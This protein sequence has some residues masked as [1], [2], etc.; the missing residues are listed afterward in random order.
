MTSEE[1]LA[2]LATKALP[3]PAEEIFDLTAALKG[4]NGNLDF[5]REIATSLDEDVPRL[6]AD[7]HAAVERQDAA[8]LE[9]AAHRLKGS[10]VPFVAPSAIKAAQILETM[11]HAQELSNASNTFHLLDTEIQRLL[12]ALKDLSSN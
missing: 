3:A 8:K 7:I 1:L 10:L 11:G 5:L 9:R 12:A 4:V 6:V 2:C